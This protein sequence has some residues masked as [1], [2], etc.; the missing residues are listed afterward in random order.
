[1]IR[2]FRGTGVALVTPFKDNGQVDY[3]GLKRVIEHT[4]KGKV[5]Y[6]VSLGTTGEPAT[7]SK[8]EKMKVL[9]F[10]IEAVK[11]RVPLVAGFGGNNTAEVIDAIRHFHFNGVDAIL[12]VSPYYNKPAQEGI[13]R[14]FRAIAD[15]SPVP[16]IVYNVPSR[17][18]S[19]IQ[20][21]T[22]LRLARD[23]K[24]IIGI[25]E[26]SGDFHQ[27]MTILRGKAEDF[28]VVSGDDAITFPL[29]FLGCDGVISVIANAFPKDFSEMVRAALNYDVIRSRK[30]HY[31]LLDM[32]S[33]L[34]REGSPAG[35]KCALELLG[36]CGSTVRLPLAPVSENL[37]KEMQAAIHVLSKAKALV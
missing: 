18:A 36:V 13:Y 35:V 25:K 21:Q 26:A 3:D 22:T 6:L 2:K 7:L 34:F 14:H 19:N 4:L 27:V 5:E 8:E 10:T 24:N 12:S 20:A 29:V 31:K 16:V 17:T 9:E 23:S 37:R 28:F 30:L 33:L 11:G 1:M 15:T 32:M